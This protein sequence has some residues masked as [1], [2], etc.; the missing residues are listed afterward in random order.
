[1]HIRLIAVDLDGT[2]LHDDMT[3]S[4]YSRNV[5]RHAAEKVRIVVATGRMFDSAREKA[6]K[7]G[8]GDIPIICYTGAW[9]GL[10][11]SGRLLH[12]DGIPANLAEKILGDGRR[13]GW[14]IQ[15][16]VEDEICLPSP[17][18]AEADCR[19]YRAKEAKYLG[20]AFYHPETDPT[21]LII[22]EAD[23]GKREQIRIY[24]EKDTAHKLRWCIPEIFFWIF[25]ERAF[26]RPMHFTNWENY[27]EL[28]RRKWS[29]LAIQKTMRP[30]C[31]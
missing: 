20:E 13:F 19:I 15:S 9:I 1:M 14:L 6:Q 8:L 29:P 7:L 11:E 27:G 5:I 24:L 26:P 2:L 25:I 12:K 10:A 23:T 28:H 30:C 17:S 3:I 21:R 31:G 18:A 16:Y 22:V 4:E